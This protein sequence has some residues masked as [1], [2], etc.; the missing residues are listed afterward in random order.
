M[1][2]RENYYVLR[3]ALDL[4]VE[5]QRKKWRQKNTWKKHVE[6]EYMK[7]AGWAG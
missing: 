6:E 1:L 5:G 4:E 7:V 2:R 3:R